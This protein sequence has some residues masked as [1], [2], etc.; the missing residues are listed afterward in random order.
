[1]PPSDQRDERELELTLALVVSVIAVHG[2][3]SIQVEEC[4][5]RAKDLS[6]KLT[7]SQNRFAAQRVAWNSSLMRRPVPRT[8]AL[9]TDLVGLAE[10][11]G[12][13]AK[14]AVA[15]RALG[16]SLFISGQFREA[17][18]LLARGAALADT[19]S[20][21]E[22]AIYGE[23]PS[24]VC[25]AYGGQVKVLMGFSESGMRLIEASIAHARH[26]NNAHSLAWALGAAAHI[27]Q[28]QH[29]PA[30]TAHFASEAIETAREHRLPQGCLSARHAKDGRFTSSAILR[31][32]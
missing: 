22:F 5:I 6:D 10:E 27:S 7:E 9:A 13:P 4:A 3:G 28:W 20:E 29:E 24:M 31:A 23:H 17:A 19:I 26:Q 11:D 25:R 15:Y 18:E 16:Y 21:G 12:D 14:L 30:A 32:D 1:L 2:F 8:S